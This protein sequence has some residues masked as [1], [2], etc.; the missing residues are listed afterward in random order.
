MTNDTIYVAKNCYLE[1]DT[2]ELWVDGDP[3]P[4]TRL[5]CRILQF[6]CMRVGRLVSAEDI[7]TYAWGP[8]REVNRAELYVYISQIRKLLAPRVAIVAVKRVGYL[9]ERSNG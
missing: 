3:T 2:L 6:F 4:L 9:F 1:V 7:V 8:H 5:Q